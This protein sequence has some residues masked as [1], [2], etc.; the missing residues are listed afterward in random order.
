MSLKEVVRTVHMKFDLAKLQGLVVD[1][2]I[3][4]LA[5]FFNVITQDVHPVMA[6]RVGPGET[7]H[8][9]T[10]TGGFSYTLPLGPWQSSI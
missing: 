1:H 3:T 2:L 9:A 8:L 6:A 5:K 4:D 10:Q 7:S